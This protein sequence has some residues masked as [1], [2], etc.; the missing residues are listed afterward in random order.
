MND[1]I[2]N[3]VHVPCDCKDC[4]KNEAILER[5]KELLAGK[6]DAFSFTGKQ[7]RTEILGEDKVT[8]TKTVCYHN[9]TKG[10]DGGI[11]CEDCNTIIQTYVLGEKRFK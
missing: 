1:Y 3:F 11:L 6:T 10:I 2:P 4:V 7:L 9:H 5:L 8:L